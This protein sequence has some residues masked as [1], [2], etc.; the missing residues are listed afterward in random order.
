M[1]EQTPVAAAPIKKKKRGFIGRAFRWLLLLGFLGA[2]GFAAYL[3]LYPVPDHEIF[4]Y[5]PKDAVF[6]LEADDPIENWKSFSNTK[7][8]RHLKK[9]GVFADIEQDADF[10][11]TLIQDNST[12]FSMVSGKKLLIA[13]QMI[14]EKDYDFLYIMDLKQGAK[15]A[16]V[17]DLFKG[18]LKSFDVPIHTAEFGGRNGYKI[19]DGPQ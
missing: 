12:I 17:M 8:W 15:I 6:V 13:A 19:G 16:A 11:D 10:L 5:V 2:A 7:I 3:Y 18:V 1:A 9:N 14:S 4:N